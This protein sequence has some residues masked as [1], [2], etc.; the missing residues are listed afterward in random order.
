MA[1]S[2]AA[3]TGDAEKWSVSNILGV[4]DAKSHKHNVLVEV[5]R[6][7]LATAIQDTNTAGCYFVVYALHDIE[8]RPDWFLR[9]VVLASLLFSKTF[10][11]MLARH[12]KAPRLARM[13]KQVKSLVG[14]VL[15]GSSEASKATG[16][17]STR[18]IVEFTRAWWRLQ[19]P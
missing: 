18:G 14:D 6:T 16:V 11:R 8:K 15:I 3:T 4:A 10:R 12:N 1:T 17:S 5:A 7:S 2:A 13:I 9:F 19:G